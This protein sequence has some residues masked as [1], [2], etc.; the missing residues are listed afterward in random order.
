MI[1]SPSIGIA[2]YAQCA[3]VSRP[4]SQSRNHLLIEVNETHRYSL[5]FV[6]ILAEAQLTKVIVTT[7]K[8]IVVL[9]KK[10]GVI[11]ATRNHDCLHFV[12]DQLG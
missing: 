12:L 3:R 2:F 4:S 8:D 9:T 11:A 7:S 1:R 6:L 5:I 10:Q